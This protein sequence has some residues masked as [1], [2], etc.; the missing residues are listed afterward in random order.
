M[1]LLCLA[2]LAVGVWQDVEEIGKQWHSTV[3]FEPK[4]SMDER[5][6]LYH[7]WKQAVVKAQGWE[8]Q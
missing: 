3:T 5:E 1:V 8:G 6:T 7:H 4:M 2:G